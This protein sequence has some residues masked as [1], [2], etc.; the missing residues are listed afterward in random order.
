M[1]IRKLMTSEEIHQAEIINSLVFYYP[2]PEDSAGKSEPNRAVW[3]ALEE[4]KVISSIFVPEYEMMYYG[5]YMP[6]FGIGGVGTRAEYRNRGYIRNIFHAIFDEMKERGYVFSYL[7]PFSFAYYSQFGYSLGTSTL[8]ASIPPNLLRDFPR[9]CEV[10]LY[11]KGNSYTPY[12]EIFETFAQNYTGMVKRP[13]WTRLEEYTPTKNQKFLYL[14]KQNGAAKAYAAFSAEGAPNSSREMDVL[15]YAWTD[16]DAMRSLFGFL[17]SMAPHFSNVKIQLPDTFPI[18]YM[19]QDL[20][21]IER[22]TNPFGQVRIIDVPKA[23]EGY[24]WPKEAG[25]ICLGVK[26]DYFDGNSGSY[27]IE[28]G[29]GGVDIK[30]GGSP[31]L[32]LDIR[33]LNPLLFGSASF[34]DVMYMDKKLFSLNHNE[35]E[36]EKVFIKRPTFITER[37]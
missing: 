12:N 19:F 31:D 16:L 30:K 34:G 25:K 2:L 14:L 18:N 22:S 17:G 9:D 1:E 29:S 10:S 4:G 8:Y 15:D 20:Y 11:E 32:E 28:Y 36:L 6:M 27:T 37:F 7:Y 35:Q 21:N 33:A 5:K 13:D 3:G 24:P 23:L 26:D